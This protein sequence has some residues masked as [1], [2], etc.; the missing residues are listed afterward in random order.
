MSVD[1]KWVERNLGFDPIATPPPAST[2]AFPRAAKTET[3]EDLQR[4]I[5]DFD[6]EVAGRL[7]VSRLS[8]RRPACRDTRRSMAER[9]APKTGRRPRRSS[10]S[11]LP[12]ADVLVVT[13]TVDEGHALSRVLTPARI[14][15]TTT[16]PTRTTSRR[17]PRRCA[18]VS[19]A[20]GKATRRVLDHDHRR[21]VGGDLQ[22]ELAHVS[23]RPET[24]EHRRVAPDH[25]RGATQ[26]GHHHRNGGRHRQAVRGGRRDRQPHSPLRLH[27]EVQEGAICTDALLASSAAKTDALRHRPIL[28][29]GECG[30]AA[31][32]QQAPAKDCRVAAE[33][34]ETPRSSRRTSSAST[35]L[36]T[37]TSCKGSATF[38]KW[39]TRSLDWSP[40][41]WGRSPA[42]AGDPQRLRP[43]DQG[44]RP[45]ASDSRQ[46]SRRRFTRASDGGV[47]YAAR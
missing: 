13:W 25:P 24:A 22:V 47:Q 29:H 23:R 1:R 37:T 31:E 5:I 36:T 38:P 15:A 14:P 7:A 4:E 10:D 26:A 18:R 35:R 27:S 9:L 41:K 2:F 30:A 21:Q 32:G 28:V 19:G 34:A 12:S 42:L 17:S 44:R 8:P 20:P 45:D 33:Q 39:E 11:P 43:A 16:C 3:P 6:S 46:R 40:P